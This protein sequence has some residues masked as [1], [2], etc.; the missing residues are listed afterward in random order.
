MK[1]GLHTDSQLLHQGGTVLNV[2][3]ARNNGH[4][5]QLRQALRFNE[6]LS[7][8]KELWP[9]LLELHSDFCLGLLYVRQEH[10]HT[11]AQHK[12]KL[13]VNVFDLL[14]ET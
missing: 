8:A 7:H 2:K 9:K 10:T 11:Q 5:H 13:D 6:A 12:T 14:R 4:L 3:F 1:S